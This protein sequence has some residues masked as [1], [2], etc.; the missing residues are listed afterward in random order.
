MK[1]KHIIGRR[2][3]GVVSFTA[4]FLAIITV[5]TMVYLPKFSESDGRHMRGF[6]EEEENSINVLMLGSCNMYSSY[7]PVIAYE[8]TGLVSYAYC[9][10]DQEICT[11]YHYLK[12]ALKTQ[13]NIQLVVLESLFLTCEPTAKREYYNR[14]AVEYLHPSWNKLE[15]IY[16]LGGM[17]SEY[18]QTMDPTAPGKTLTYAGYLF[19]LLR[20]HSR[21]DVSW[22]ED[23]AW[24][25]EN[26]NY[27]VLKGGI[28]LY[29]Y[30]NNETLDFPYVL[31]GEVVRD[32]SREYFIKIQELCQE[33]GIELLLAKSPNHYRWD[34]EAISAIHAFAE[35]RNVPLLDFHDYDDFL[36]SDYSTTTGRLNVYGMKKF[37][38]HM[39]DYIQENYSIRHTPLSPE[40]QARWDECVALFHKTSNK[41]DMSIDENTIYRIKNEPEGIQLFWNRCLDCGSF[42]VYRQASGE[43]AYQKVAT[44]E[45]STWLDETV[46][47]NTGY[48][49]YV[50]P[51]EGQYQG[52]ASNTK[53]YYFLEAPTNALW[54]RTD[55]QI[56]LQW[57]AA[58][59][60]GY[61]L[62]RKRSDYL[63]YSSLAT[64]SSGETGYADTEELSKGSR[65][66]YRLRSMVELEGDTYYSGAVVISVDPLK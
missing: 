21:E 31:N 63:N 14:L 37:T 18:M 44:V 53:Y 41:K 54:Q 47:P 60:D 56:S 65:F 12:E 59:V 34:E 38:E 13:E 1:S 7:S 10:P 43:E 11:A 49:Y 6:Y 15:L 26:D 20:Y 2:V 50:V 42:D 39:C 29:S 4:L 55:E 22:E 40:N 52:T 16:E 46:Q 66:E 48:R 33:N 30:L 57:D 19:P 28:P 3:A 35:E 8:Q 9:C 64:L 17:E 5:L 61:S 58:E 32:T 24:W 51:T 25:W 45:G 62:Q 27:S 23:I 36:L